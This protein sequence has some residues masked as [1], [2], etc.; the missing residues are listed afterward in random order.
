MDS[1]EQPHEPAA[2]GPFKCNVCGAANESKADIADRESPTCAACHS[3][4]RFRSIILVLS[5]ALFGMDLT[6]P[7]FPRLRSLRGMGISDASI[8]SARLADHFSYINTFY[9]REPAFDLTRPDETEF[10]KYDFV[11]ASEVLEHVPPPVDRAFETL[12]RLL[13]PAGVLILTVP[14]SLESETI[15][16]FP[17]LHEAGLAEINGTPVLLNRSE[18]GGYEVFDRLVFHG[19]RGSTLEMREFS[20]LDVRARLVAA[21]FTKVRVEATGNPRF[22]VVFAG[23]WSLPIIATKEPF[24]LGVSGIG[25]LAEQLAAY[26]AVLDALRKSR[27]L[28]LGRLVGLGPRIPP[29]E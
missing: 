17:A 28:R 25:E 21:G 8:Y 19:G 7:E 4:I 6:L 12:S 26:R 24:S 29:R 15:E 10:G 13:K 22:G 3:S 16:H 20:E 9:H 5:R 18:T 11:I 27:W 23:P 14:Y 1:H 2:I